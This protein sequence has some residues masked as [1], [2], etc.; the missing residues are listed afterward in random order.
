MVLRIAVIT[1]I[2]VIAIISHVHVLHC[3]TAFSR[4]AASSPGC[5]ARLPCAER[6]MGRWGVGERERERGAGRWREESADIRSA[7]K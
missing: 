2:L 7:Q 4:E 6:E 3:S 1:I 5:R